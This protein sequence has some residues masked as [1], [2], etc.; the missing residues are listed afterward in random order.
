MLQTAV[1]EL[2]FFFAVNLKEFIINSK[3]GGGKRKYCAALKVAFNVSGCLFLNA[4]C[5]SVEL[6]SGKSMLTEQKKK[7]L[8]GNKKLFFPPRWR[9]INHKQQTQSLRSRDSL[10]PLWPFLSY[11]QTFYTFGNTP[12]QHSL[13]NSGSFTPNHLQSVYSL[14]LTQIKHID[15]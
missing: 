6:N 11:K 12:P 15:K 13:H 3:H 1:F 7:N 5:D 14:Y 2:V 9:R 10:P 4:A 8:L